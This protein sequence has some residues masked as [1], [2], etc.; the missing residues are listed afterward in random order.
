MLQNYTWCY[1][2]S[3]FSWQTFVSTT[4]LAFSKSQIHRVLLGHTES[5][6]CIEYWKTGNDYYSEQ[7]YK[8]Q[9]RKRTA[10]GSIRPEENSLRL[11]KWVREPITLVGCS[12]KLY[13]SQITSVSWKTLKLDSSRIIIIDKIS[14]SLWN[15]KDGMALAEET[16]RRCYRADKCKIVLLMLYW[17]EAHCWA[18]C[19]SY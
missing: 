8:S 12:L 17:I 2:K 16:Y 19:L 18:Q 7:M 6:W 11:N 15:Q 10:D 3:R 9:R 5:I 1:K 4:V 14:D 13:I